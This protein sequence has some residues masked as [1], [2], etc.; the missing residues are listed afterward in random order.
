MS[1]RPSSASALLKIGGGDRRFRATASQ[2][3][4]SGCEGTNTC[5]Q[6]QVSC[7]TAVALCARAPT[8]DFATHPRQTLLGATACLGR[9]R[10]H[11]GWLGA[12]ERQTHQHLLLLARHFTGRGG[13]CT[14]DCS[15]PASASATSAR[16]AL[17]MLGRACAAAQAS[18]GT[19]MQTRGHHLVNDKAHLRNQSQQP[20][21]HNQRSVLVHSTLLSAWHPTFSRNQKRSQQPAYALCSS[22][23][24]GCP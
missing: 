11:Q 9:L 14:E 24:A 8:A 17:H 2:C 3:F 7:F 12:L 20:P 6:G 22:G 16:R 15:S 5:T 10:M 1:T 4:T 21:L 19:G 18:R 23:A 13:C